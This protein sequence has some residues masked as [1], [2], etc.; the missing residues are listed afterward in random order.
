MRKL[1]SIGLPL[2]IEI[3]IDNATPQFQQLFKPS[4][5]SGKDF[6]TNRRPFLKRQ[7]KLQQNHRL[8]WDF[9]EKDWSNHL[10]LVRHLLGNN[11]LRP[12]LPALQ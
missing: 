11:K 1:K 2:I 7:R 9:R 4:R 5:Y 10:D 6:N 3:Q 12:A 8:P